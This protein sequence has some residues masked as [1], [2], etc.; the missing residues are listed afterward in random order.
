MYYAAFPRDG[1]KLTT[2]DAANALPGS[3][4]NFALE[5]TLVRLTET[6]R[7]EGKTMKVNM[8]A[9]LSPLSRV[10]RGILQDQ[11][12]YSILSDALTDTI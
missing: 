10:S 9:P 5:G 12:A 7:D 8:Q 6:R 2:K 11:I 1:Q 4:C 3:S